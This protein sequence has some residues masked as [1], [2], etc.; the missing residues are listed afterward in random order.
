MISRW[1]VS[2]Q[3]TARD[4][5]LVRADGDVVTGRVGTR[6]DSSR[7]H[8]APVTAHRRFQGVESLSATMMCVYG[9]ESVDRGG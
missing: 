5:A 4:S 3:L 6:H 7:P 9:N 8:A 2:A 1:Q